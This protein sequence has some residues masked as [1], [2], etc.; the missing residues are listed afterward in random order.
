M[1]SSDKKAVLINPSLQSHE[2][3]KTTSN[4][5]ILELHETSALSSTHSITFPENYANTNNQ[6]DHQSDESLDFSISPETLARLV[7]SKDANYLLQFGGPKKVAFLLETDIQNGIFGDQSDLD[8]RHKAFGSN[9]NQYCHDHQ[10]SLGI[11]QLAF[12][13]CKDTTIILLLCCAVLSLAI[14][15]KRYGPQE[16]I[17]DGILIFLCILVLVYVGVVFQYIKSRWMIKKRLKQKR[18]AYVVRNGKCQRISGSEVVVGD[19]VCL[20][21]GSE[22]PADGLF[23]NDDSSSFKLDCG[24]KA[25]NFSNFPS[26]F[27]GAKVA[28]GGCKMLVTSVGEKTE[29]SKLMGLL[30]NNSKKSNDFYDSSSKLQLSIEKIST[31]LENVWLIL[32]LLVLVVQV[33][34]CFVWESKYCDKNHNPDPKGLKDSLQEV[35]HETAKIMKKQTGKV[36][37]LVAMLCILMFA[38]RDCLPLGIFTTFFYASKKLKPFR[39]IIQKLPACAT[40]GWIT[41]ICI[42]NTDDLALKYSNMADLWIGMK[43]IV[44]EDDNMSKEVNHQVV[45]F[46]QEAIFWT[47]DSAEVQEIEEDALF[48]WAEKVLSM[49]V[50]KIKK[51]CSFNHS[52]APDIH[53]N[54]RSVIPEQP[55]ESNHAFDVYWKGDPGM[56]LLMCSHYLDVD[57]TMQ[58]LDEEKRQNFNQIIKD[59]A[60]SSLRCFAFAHKQIFKKEY[61]GEEFL[62]S[63]ED[64]LI[65]LGLVNLKNPYPPEVIQSV[66][67]CVKSGVTIKLVV[68]D[69]LKTAG[70]MAR[71]SGILGPGKDLNQAVVHASIFRNSSPEE[72]VKMIDNIHVLADASPEDKLWM[73]Q[74][75]RQKSEVVA[76]T[77]RCSRDLPSLREADVSL[78]MGDHCAECIKEDVE[79]VV[80]GLSIGM[81]S[82][83]V[84]F[85]R[86]VC[87]NLEKFIDFQLTVNVAAF[88][89]NFI[90]VLTTSEVQFTAFELL[91]VN[92]I[93]EVFGALALSIQMVELLPSESTNQVEK[94]PKRNNHYGTGSVVTKTMW[95][96]IALHS[97]FQV[98]LMV[99]LSKKGGEIL[100]ADEG[101]LKTMIFLFYVMC[102]VFALV[103]CMEINE[104]SF[105][106][107]LGKFKNH[108]FLIIVGIIVVMQ[109]ALIEV[110]AIVAHW[111]K[112]NLTQWCIC[113]G[114]AVLSMPIDYVVNWI[115]HHLSALI[116]VS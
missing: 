67:A 92:I 4:C 35:A 69:D 36:N 75:L 115:K 76:V 47:N 87:Q 52:E 37:G 100:H 72:R 104:A 60:S 39:A 15:I 77:G 78:L 91:W 21:K 10:S 33:L 112:I 8:R 65:L 6:H 29:R 58:E 99:I 16:G 81:I 63:F 20:Q 25:S 38:I 66:E 107:G 23:I 88:G 40:L 32:T 106:E 45:K 7:E 14:G 48:C 53:R 83:L 85:G 109:V 86:T 110:M 2:V 84:R 27:T 22:V 3:S 111:R 59:I 61:D 74:C 82:T 98:S 5:P 51:S 101:V 43:K 64:G 49:D 57:G 50:E 55:T 108:M 89:I 17:V 71:F 97:L 79:V 62:E 73:V 31:N 102:Q 93:M 113:T 103:G 80:F 90:V 96:N 28:E 9:Q 11:H 105:L 68:D 95:R 42:C 46:F 116:N 54:Y 114:L 94:L 13:A 12:E 1:D 24:H 26:L 41:T 56:I 18:F 19:I 30:G 44:Q 34:R 70:F